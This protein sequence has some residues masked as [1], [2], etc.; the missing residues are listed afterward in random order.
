MLQRSGSDER[1]KLNCLASVARCIA[2]IHNPPQRICGRRKRV[3]R[4]QFI[5]HEPPKTRISAQDTELFGGLQ[6]ADHTAAMTLVGGQQIFDPFVLAPWSQWVS[7]EQ[8]YVGGDW[9][10]GGG[11]FRTE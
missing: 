11:E 8:V 4:G 9:F 6:P 10:R 7:A 5:E 1:E 3:V 2:L